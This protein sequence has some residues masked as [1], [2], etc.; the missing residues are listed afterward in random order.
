MLKGDLK[1]MNP[2][3]LRG[4]SIVGYGCSLAVALGIPIPILD[5]EMAWFTGVSD[6]DIQVPV[7]DYGEDY[8]NGYPSPYGHVSFSQLKKGIITVEGKEVPTTPLTSYTLSL[9]VAEELKRWI[10]E[11]RFLLTEAQEA[12]PA[13]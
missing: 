2:R 11:G 8:P 13:R 7:V 5:E 1:G 6:D 9:E 3:Y 4:V 10:T 12:I